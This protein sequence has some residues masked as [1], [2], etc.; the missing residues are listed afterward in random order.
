MRKRTKAAF[1]VL[2]WMLCGLAARAEVPEWVRNLARAQAKTYADDVNAVA[3]LDE[4]ETTINDKG[5][6]VTHGRVAYRILRPEGRRYATVG[7]NFDSET[8]ITYLKGWSITAKGQEYEA[9]EKDAV[10]R[11]KTSY[12]VYSD[13]KEKILSLPGADVGT[14]VAFEVEQKGRPYIFQHRWI[15]QNDIPVERTRCTLRLPS[16][17]E[18]KASWVNHAEVKPTNINGAYV[19]ELTD[20]PRIEREFNRPP[21][22]TLAGQVFIT[23][24]SE[25]FKNLSYKDWNDLG[26]WH[27]Q[28]ISASFDSSPS[29]Q[30][31]VQELAPSS[32][33]PLERIRNLARFAQRDVRYA[34]IEVGIGGFRPHPASEVFTHRYGDCKDK[35]TLLKSMLNQIGIKSYYMPIH[36]ERGY[37]VEKSPPNLGFN[38]VILAIQL[39]DASLG[40][41]LPALYEHPKLGHL[42]IFD[43]TDE[44]VPFGQL[45]WYEQDSYSLL[46]TENGGE[47]IH[48]PVTKPEFNHIARTA[49]MKLLPDGSLQGEIEDTMSGFFASSVRELRDVSQQDRK[50]IIES[51]LGRAVGSFQMD[52]FDVLNA[53]DPDKDIVVRYK[54]TATHYAKAAGPLLL[55]R[56][57]VVG[58]MAGFFDPSKPRHYSYQFRA[59]QSESDVF[60]ITLPD[61]FKVD[62][63]PEPAKAAFSFGEY[64]SKA[65][66]SGN[67]LKYTREYKVGTTLVPLEKFDELKKLFS[68]INIDE[69]NMAV[70]KRA[71]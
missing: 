60:E 27:A 51:F 55:V 43:P 37:I 21:M 7:F 52:S 11:S 45:P 49:K 29:L 67:V 26:A 23:F 16:S 39:P 1:L 50:K 28:L 31:K 70:L 15:F 56:P 18:F 59:P 42:L 36:N 68:Q 62:E 66:N 32:L 58:E 46:V 35:A 20:V 8:K 10:E 53:D 34:A 61:G 13:E 64:H 6:M 57:R 14:V 41:A 12:E 47:L 69:K 22:L 4:E 25:K 19:W 44:F 48:L 17:W 30:Q 40:K 9:K 38:H 2:G 65:E 71:N 33:P 3:L 24:V 63:L 54:F 5:E